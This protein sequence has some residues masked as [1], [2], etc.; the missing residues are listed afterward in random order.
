MNIGE[1]IK[2]NHKIIKT[3]Y[4]YTILTVIDQFIYAIIFKNLF[5]CI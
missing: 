1:Q 3:Q 5:K 4:Y 2:A